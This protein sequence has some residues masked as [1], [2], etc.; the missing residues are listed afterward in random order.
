MKQCFGRLLYL[1]FYNNNSKTEFVYNLVFIHNKAYIKRD[2]LQLTP[3]ER[4]ESGKVRRVSGGVY[5]DTQRLSE[6][7]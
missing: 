5:Q 3:R 4:A 1:P 7:P 2:N 6:H